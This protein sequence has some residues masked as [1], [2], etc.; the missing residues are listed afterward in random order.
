MTVKVKKIP[1]CYFV[2]KIKEHKQIK[3]K[4]LSLIEKIPKNQWLTPN[5]NV[6][7]TDWNLPREHKREYLDYFYDIVRPYMGEIK[8]IL[9]ERTW[10]ITNGWFQ[11]YYQ[12]DSHSWHR[13]A[14]VNWGNVYYLELPSTKYTSKYQPM[15]NSK[16]SFNFEAKEGDMVT[17]PATLKHTSERISSDTRKTII[18]FNSDFF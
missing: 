17:F 11:Q 6:T 8:E 5:E 1:G 10:E 16:K 18:S 13:H 4:L 3:T 14:G 15:A 7:H 12:N 2:T 9:N